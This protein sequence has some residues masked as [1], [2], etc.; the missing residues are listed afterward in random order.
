MYTYLTSVIQEEG[1]QSY[2]DGG[3]EGIADG[4]GQLE[5]LRR[6]KY[7]R[8]AYSQHEHSG[9]ERHKPCPSTFRR[10]VIA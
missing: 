4:I 3:G 6:D 8:G 2:R 1:C 10:A 7:E 5:T 9:K